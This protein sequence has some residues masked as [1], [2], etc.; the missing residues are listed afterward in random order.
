[1]NAT[2]MTHVL[3]DATVGDWL[4]GLT[5]VPPPALAERLHSSLHVHRT[6]PFTEVPDACL[7]AGEA[8]L[9]QMLAS[10]STSRASAL[11]L[12]AVDALITYAFEQASSRPSDLLQRATDAMQRIASIPAASDNAT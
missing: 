10:G 4:S 12:L 8:M 5:P 9:T 2:S 7:D 3:T 6:R 11:D 1:M